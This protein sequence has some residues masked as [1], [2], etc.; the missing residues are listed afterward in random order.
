MDHR[1]TRRV[2]LRTL[3]AAAG[4]TMG[5]SVLLAQQLPAVPVPAAGPTPSGPLARPSAVSLIHGE[6]RRKIVC[7]SLVAIEDQILPLLRTKKHVVIKPNMVSTQEQL[8]ATHVT[9]CT[10]SWTSWRRVSRVLS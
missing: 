9:R 8:A 7:E 5:G 1:C 10:A 2:F 6:S 4:A 3:G